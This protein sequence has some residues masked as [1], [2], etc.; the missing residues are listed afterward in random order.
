MISFQCDDTADIIIIVP[1]DKRAPIFALAD[2]KR[3]GKP[4]GIIFD[5]KRSG[6]WD[7]SFWDVNLDDTFAMKG[8]HPGGQ[9]IPKTFVPRCGR[10]QPLTDLRCA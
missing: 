5:S 9:L 8:L 2:T 1:D 3:L 10:G 7:I 4:D 6:K